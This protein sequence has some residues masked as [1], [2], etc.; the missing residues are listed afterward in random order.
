[1]Y[2]VALRR[3]VNVCA[4]TRASSRILHSVSRLLAREPTL[5]HP[6]PLHG[7]CA[8]QSYVAVLYPV[9]LKTSTR[10]R[11]LLYP[12]AQAVR[13]LQVRLPPSLRQRR[14]VLLLISAVMPSSR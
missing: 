9:R 8:I 11:V 6:Y 10:H 5:Q 1:M 14:R 3:T 12:R 2:P 13:P 7:T 4:A